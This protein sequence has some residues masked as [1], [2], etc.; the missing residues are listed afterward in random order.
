M[1]TD[2]LVFGEPLI[3]QDEIDELLD[4]VKNSW[5]GTGK[6]VAIFEKDFAAYKK[7]KHIAA[8]NSCTAALHLACLALGI[9][10]GDEIIT[11]AMTF[12][13]TVNAIIHAGAT[14][15]LADIDSNTLNIA[16]GQI[17]KK[18]T[19]KTKAIIVVHFAGRPCDMDKIMQIAR[20]NNIFVIE[21]CAHAIESEYNSKPVGTIGDIGCFSFYATK[22]ITTGEGGMV[23]SNN[24]K[25][26]SKVKTLALHGLS[27]DAWKR[28]SDEGFKH[29]FVEEAGF[30]YNM[31]DLQASFGIHQLK[32]ID[33]Y[34]ERRK[35]IWNFYNKELKDLPITLPFA[36]VKK[37]KHSYHLY[38]I[39]IDKSK[40]GLSRDEFL[41]R[42]HKMNIGCGVHYLSIPAHPY[43]KKTYHLKESD[44]PNASIYG[45]ETVSLPLSPKLTREDVTDVVNTVKKI[46]NH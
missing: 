13:G 2:F 30:K 35:E 40:C 7:A 33:K 31:T 4:S 10:R 32:R 23:I 22:N 37:C 25:I 41:Q 15:V 27:H 6:K 43:Y 16:P 12:C 36:E 20:K 24:Q 19:K 8:V 1:R 34:W 21:D 28:F 5:L 46:L 14:P 44:F 38:T 11:S 39:R 3:E 9:K 42:M 26:I 29:Y 45:R 17:E 18:I